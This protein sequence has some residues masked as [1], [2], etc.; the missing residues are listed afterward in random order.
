MNTFLKA[1]ILDSP[2]GLIT[3]AKYIEAVLYHPQIGYYMRDKQK[4]GRQGDFITTSNISDIY[5]RIVAKWFS[6]VCKKAQLAPTFCEIGAGN[7]RFAHAFLQEWK[8]S[9][10]TPLK[11]IIVDSSPFHRKLQRELLVTDFPLVHVDSI[12]DVEAFEGMIFSN[13]LFDALP[14]HVIEK[15]NGD[16]YE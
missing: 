3:Y 5:G 13:E 8:E 10:Q 7:G 2:N 1:L 16:L 11:Y 14:V 6:R 9:I 4:I 12:N 15:L